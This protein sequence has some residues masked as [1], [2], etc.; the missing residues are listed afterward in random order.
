MTIDV[1][2]NF[3]ATSGYVTDPAGTTYVLNEGYPTTRGG[4][5]FG[6][7]TL[8]GGN[9][10]DRSTTI[11]ARLAG[12]H[13]FSNG[14]SKIKFQ[15]DLPATGSTDIYCSIGDAGA[16]NQGYLELFDDTTSL[17]ILVAKKS[18]GLATFHDATDIGYSAADWPAS[19]AKATH[20]FSTSTLIVAVTPG[21]SAGSNYVITHLRVVQSGGGGS[22]V[23]PV[24]VN[25]YRNQGIM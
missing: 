12:I 24:F 19:N 15:V 25:H 9:M 7:L 22:V 16:A 8:P 18:I 6:W 23:V 14:A 13:Y 20:S 5:T 11:D 21:D 1:G 2:F 17:G 10:R 3:R 4:A